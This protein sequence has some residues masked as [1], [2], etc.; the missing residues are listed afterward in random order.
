MV[1]LNHKWLSF[2]KGT[3]LALLGSALIAKL[4]MYEVEHHAENKA[5]KIQIIQ[6]SH[7]NIDGMIGY[8]VKLNAYSKIQDIYECKRDGQLYIGDR[9]D[10]GHQDKTEIQYFGEGFFNTKIA[11]YHLYENYM[12]H[13]TAALDRL[14][15][16]ENA[17]DKRNIIKFKEWES[18]HLIDHMI[19]VQDLERWDKTLFNQP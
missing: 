12:N 2:L 1:A 10:S 11:D 13:L 6:I 4:V 3:I 16:Y 15:P 17:K 19:A 7:K 9:C 18:Q 8:G 14:M 5:E